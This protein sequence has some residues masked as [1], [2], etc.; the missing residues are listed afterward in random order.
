MEIKKTLNI[1]YVGQ[2]KFILDIFKKKYKNLSKIIC[3]TS[4]SGDRIDLNNNTYSLAKKKM[5]EFLIQ[6]NK[7]FIKKKII[8]KDIKP[9]Y[10]KTKFIKDMFIPHLIAS[11]PV[12]IAQIIF[13]AIDNHKKVIYAPSYW[14]LI[15]SV[16]NNFYKILNFFFI[17]K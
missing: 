15:A 9:G 17:K 11:K 12:Y 13:D 4:V 2:K 8:V 3:I 6:I 1:N 14:K 10:V 7:K 5:S 16:Y